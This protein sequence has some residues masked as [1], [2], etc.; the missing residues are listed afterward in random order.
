MKFNFAKSEK[1]RY[2]LPSF[3]LNGRHRFK[4][5]WVDNSHLPSIRGLGNVSSSYISRS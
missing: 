5:M 3:G 4:I 2:Q 1:Q